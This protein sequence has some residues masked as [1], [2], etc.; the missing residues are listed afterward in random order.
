MKVLHVINISNLGGAENLLLEVAPEMSR[1]GVDLE[2]IIFN[3]KGHDAAA[4]HIQARLVHEGLKVHRSTYSHPLQRSIFKK[5]ATYMRAILL[6]SF[7][8]I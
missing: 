3:K 4:E 2:C 1:L 5:S 6:I 8:V 7:T